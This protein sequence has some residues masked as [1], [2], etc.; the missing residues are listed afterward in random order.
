MRKVNEYLL[1]HFAETFV[2]VKKNL[3]VKASLHKGKIF[4]PF[5][6]W[7]WFVEI[8]AFVVYTVK[9]QKNGHLKFDK[10]ARN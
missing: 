6:I 4:A 7:C 1:K 5:S 9:G 10:F 2:A 3:K 8:C